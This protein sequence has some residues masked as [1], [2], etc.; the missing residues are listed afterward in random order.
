MFS[1]SRLEPRLFKFCLANP[2]QT[3]KY[4]QQRALLAIFTSQS[5]GLPALAKMG[6]DTQGG[7]GSR[8]NVNLKTSKSQN[9]A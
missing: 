5:E 9:Y 6:T 4:Q 1:L 2:I 8:A 7:L 3:L